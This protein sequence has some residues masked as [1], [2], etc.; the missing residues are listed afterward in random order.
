MPKRTTAWL[1]TNLTPI[2]DGGDGEEYLNA[3]RLDI[4]SE[5]NPTTVHIG[6]AA[7]LL[8]GEGRDFQEGIDSIMGK[9]DAFYPWLKPHIQIRRKPKL[10]ESGK[11]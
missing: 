7:C 3:S 6:I 5:W 8:T 1:L 9:V 10:R 11:P 2:T 4:Y